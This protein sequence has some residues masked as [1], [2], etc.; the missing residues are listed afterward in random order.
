MKI[1]LLIMPILL[2]LIMA[3]AIWWI[4]PGYQEMKSKE[5]NLASAT[6]RLA[7]IKEK[8]A[9]AEKLLNIW[10]NSAE[11]RNI[12]EKYIPG[13]K[14]EEDVIGS[15]NSLVS[16]TGLALYDLSVSATEKKTAPSAG[17]NMIEAEADAV[18]LT[19][20]AENFNVALG[21]AGD[22][23]KIKTLLGKISALKRFNSVSSL[24]ISSSSGQAGALQADITLNFNYIRRTNSAINPDNKI[25]LT[26]VFD[27]GIAD[28]ITRK[29]STDI[30]ST[31][32]G[33]SGRENPFVR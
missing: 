16:E 6:A 8:N 7:V 27:I 1:K 9:K 15:L 22:Y 3:L 11:Q 18:N 10:S 30:K 20:T 13:Q 33:S 25:F 12:I 5:A 2:V 31:V 26:G 29:L 24:K 4:Y 21:V 28:E 17:E 23:G 19:P 14:Q 32:V